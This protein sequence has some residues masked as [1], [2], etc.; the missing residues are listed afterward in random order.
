MFP[1]EV[2]DMQREFIR[3][4]EA[5]R[6]FVFWS[7]LVEEETKE[8]LQAHNEDEGMEQVFKESADLMYVLCGFYNTMPVRTELLLQAELNDTVQARFNEAMAALN[9]VI[10]NYMLPQ[11]LMIKAMEMVHQSN[12]TKVG[13]DGL[14][15]RSD[16][17]DGNAKGKIL[18]GPNY[19][20]P[21]M[22]PCVAEYNRFL[23][24]L[25]DAGHLEKVNET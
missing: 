22:I 15:I 1:T 3:V 18:K 10:A 4:F 17:T 11:Y 24:E 21:D 23:D 7:E 5:P 25:A 13:D 6:D 20:A 12:M 16:G 19:V 9:M 8:L 14:P 2:F